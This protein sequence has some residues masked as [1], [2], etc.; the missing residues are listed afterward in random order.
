MRRRW[1]LVLLAAAPPLILLCFLL[2][3]TR[4]GGWFPVPWAQLLS[5][6]LVLLLPVAMCALGAARGG[7]LGPLRVPLWTLAVLLQVSMAAMVWLSDRP[8]V[9]VVGLPASMVVMLL[10]LGLGPLLLTCWAY[11]AVFDSFTLTEDDLRHLRALTPET[12]G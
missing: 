8:E 1:Y 7:E 11:A 2:P 3:G 9:T 4:L 10:G 5:A 12:E 6:V